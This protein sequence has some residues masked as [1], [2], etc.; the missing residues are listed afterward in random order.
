MYTTI[1]TIGR[2]VT[3]TN[4]GVQSPMSDRRW[5]EFQGDVLATIAYAAECIE[6]DGWDVHIL[7]SHGVGVWQGTDEDTY[8]ITFL[9]GVMMDAHLYEQVRNALKDAA[10]AYKQE[11][12]A[13][14]GNV[15]ADM[16]PPTS[17]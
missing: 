12:I 4:T 5:A 1:V 15:S 13:L 3:H 2:N 11:A 10:Y 16:V 9:H 6:S 8:T 7:E 17:Y 14:I